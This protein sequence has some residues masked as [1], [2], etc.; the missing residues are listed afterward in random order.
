MNKAFLLGFI[1]LVGFAVMLPFAPAQDKKRSDAVVKV[2]AKL[3]KAPPGKAV[4][5]L[6]LEIEK[7]WH[8]YAN[9]PE[10]E[11]LDDS[12]VTVKV[13]GVDSAVVEYPKGKQ[14]DDKF[15]GKYRLY[16]DKAEI[17]VTLD[18]KAGDKSPI[19]LHIYLQSCSDKTPMICLPPATAKVTV[20]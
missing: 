16:E 18:R 2:K 3:D 8:L 6:N 4:V 12:K 14:V 17:R 11:D 9:P 20:P 13:P 19:N 15:L 10:H 5:V 7:G 1:T